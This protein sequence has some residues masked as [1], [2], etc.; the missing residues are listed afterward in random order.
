LSATTRAHLAES[1]T[2]LSEALQANVVKQGV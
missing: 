2:T 1:L